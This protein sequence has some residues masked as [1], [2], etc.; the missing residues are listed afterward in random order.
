M[1]T[2]A[3][4]GTATGQP[5][6]PA[7]GTGDGNQQTGHA[8]GQQQTGQTGDGQTGDAGDG[9]TTRSPEQ[10]VAYWK[11][12]ARKH[13]DRA[14]GNAEAAT[15]LRK[16]EDANKSAL[17]L[18][19]ERA[20]RAEQGQAEANAERHRLLAAATHGLTPELV[21][22]LGTG[23]ENEIFGRAEVLNT[24]IDAAVNARLAAELAKYGI[25]PGRD[26]GQAAGSAQAAASLAQGRR[27]VQQL[28]SGN[29]PAPQASSNGTDK[30]AAFRGMLGMGGQ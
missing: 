11:S 1:T 6:A 26:Q 25:Q 22:F 19:E 21:D 15:R 20:A 24:Q 18:A 28:R 7:T 4:E 5:T 16:L 17:Q 23:T 10:D 27:P 9:T 12:M 3:G 29:G 2:S 8:D 13:E 30:N 14:K